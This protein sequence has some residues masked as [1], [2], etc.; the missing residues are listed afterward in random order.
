[1]YGHG[2]VPPS[3]SA[4][5]VITLRVLFAAAGFLSCGLLACMPLFRVAALRGRWY[6]W[7]AAYVSLPL[8]IGALAV[9]GSVPE[10]DVR[11]D[12]ALATALI[13]GAAA[14]AYFVMVDVQLGRRPQFGPGPQG[15]GA[16]GPAAPTV[17]GY[18]Q[19][20]PPVSPYATTHVPQQPPATPVPHPHT[21]IPQPHTPVP[22][23]PP[24]HGSTAPGPVPPPQRPAPARID[25][26]RAEL[27]ELSDFLRKQ[28]GRPGGDHEGGR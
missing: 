25:Q 11:S 10:T 21:P 18:A 16:H 8:S 26:V 24:A 2:A 22:Q 13:L 5:T 17:F 4:G 14:A 6:D 15:P 3:R 1:M 12:I 23:P 9:V 20:T 19:P 28:E 27:D 7:T